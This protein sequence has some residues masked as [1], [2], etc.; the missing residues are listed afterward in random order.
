M[1]LERSDVEKIAHLARLGLNEADI[2]RT[3]ETLNNILGLIDAMQ[4]VD[5]DGIEPMA[6]PLD[7]TQRLRADS[8]TEENRRDAYQA[9]AP[10][11][12]NG[13]YLVPKVIE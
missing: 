9:I 4:A 8:V 11:V 3:T 7:A 6:H 10:A 12:E 5:T 2:P 1:A 13:L